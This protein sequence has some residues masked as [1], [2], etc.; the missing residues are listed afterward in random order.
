MCALSYTGAG[1]GSRW[2]VWALWYDSAIPRPYRTPRPRCHARFSRRVNISF[3][4]PNHVPAGGQ[5]ERAAGQCSGSTWDR[6]HAAPGGRRRLRCAPKG[7]THYAER[8]A[9]G[10]RAALAKART[11]NGIAATT[12]RS[13]S[14]GPPGP[15]C[16]DGAHARGGGC[17]RRSTGPT[18]YSRCSSSEPVR[19]IRSG[20]ASA[21]LASPGAGDPKARNPHQQPEHSTGPS[22]PND[23]S[24]SRPRGGARP[25]DLSDEAYEDFIFGGSH[26]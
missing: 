20:A 16:L 6:L 17:S 3:S 7:K 11:R 13:S 22:S 2:Q 25:L 15:F 9:R 24:R 10:I 8:G 14:P 23:A 5:M 1:C 21:E 18:T 19:A 26:L 4:H 12:G